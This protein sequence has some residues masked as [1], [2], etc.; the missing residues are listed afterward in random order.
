MIS[1]GVV[2][3]VTGWVWLGFFSCAAQ[4]AAGQQREPAA[5][6]AGTQPAVTLKAGDPAPP[7]KIEKWLKSG[8]IERF[9]KGKV[10]VLEFWATWCPPCIASMPHL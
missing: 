10:Y 3:K 4:L 1:N 5:P 6:G 2:Q 7:L 9:E 8:P